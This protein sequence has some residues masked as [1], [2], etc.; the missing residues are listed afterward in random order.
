MLSERGLAAALESLVA[1]SPVP[2]EL[3][4]PRE[5]VTPAAEAAMYF[6]VAEALTNIAKQPKASLARLQLDVEG[7]ELIAE[8]ID[9][10]VGGAAATPTSG[11]RGLTVRLEALGGTLTVESP[12]GDGTIIRACV[13]SRPASAER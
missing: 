6:T 3:R 2:V 5:R 8:V 12:A 11:L 10:G 1:R 4:V 9:D 7:G 13:P